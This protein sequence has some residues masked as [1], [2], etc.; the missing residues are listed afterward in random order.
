MAGGVVV[1]LL[2]PNC[3][4]IDG[5]FRPS[6]SS[7]C[8]RLKTMAGLVLAIRPTGLFGKSFAEKV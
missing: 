6:A 4:N 1:A 8:S 5:T 7:C 3:C 2:T